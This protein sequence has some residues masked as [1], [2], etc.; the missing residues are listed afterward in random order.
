MLDIATRAAPVWRLPAMASRPT[1]I[2][3]GAL[4]AEA[5]AAGVPIAL[6][7]DWAAPIEAAALESWEP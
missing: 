2:D 5:A 4:A 3:R 1:G 7:H 6:A